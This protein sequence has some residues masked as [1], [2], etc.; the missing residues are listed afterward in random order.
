M[1][2]L[3][4][5]NYLVEGVTD[6]AVARTLLRVGGATPGIERIMGGKSKLLSDL[7]KYNAAAVHYP[8]LAI[9]DMDHDAQCAP[10]LRQQKSSAAEQL[11][12]L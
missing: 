10:T 1:P 6:A 4:E 12:V 9:R 3:L 8:W 11:D 7:P 2:S 5:V